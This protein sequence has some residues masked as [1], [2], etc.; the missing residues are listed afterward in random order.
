M[1]KFDEAMLAPPEDNMMAETIS[2]LLQRLTPQ[3]GKESLLQAFMPLLPPFSAVQ[4]IE[5]HFP[6]SRVWYR[7]FEEGI[8]ETAAVGYQGTVVDCSLHAV[9]LSDMLMVEIRFIRTKGSK[10]SVQ[11]SSLFNW[12]VRIMTPVLE[13]LLGQAEQQAT[14]HTL[15]KERDHHRVLVDITNAVL[16]HRDRDELIA[17]VTREI[18]H[19]FGIT[20]VGMVLHDNRPSAGFVL[21][22]TH[23]S[24]TPAE[25]LQ[26]P[27]TV[28]SALMQRISG[29]NQHALLHQAEDPLL[30]QHDPLLQDL[31]SSGLSCALL[32]PLTF[33]RHTSGLLL[34]AHSSSCL[35]SDEN[36]TLLQHIANR[37]AI[38]VDNADAWHNMNDLKEQLKQ[39]NNQLNE[40]LHCSQHV[41]DIIYQSQV[42]EE[43]LQQ[44]GIV[45]QSDSTV[46]LCGETGTGKE[47][48]A[49]TIHQ[50]SLRHDKPLVKINCAAIPAALLESELFGH[51]KGAFTGA[52][53]THRGRFEIA[54]GGTLFLDEIGDLPLELQPKLLRVLQEKEIERLGGNRTIPVNVRVIAAT[55]RDLWQMVEDRQFRSDL[56]YRLNVFPLELP[57]LRDRPEDIPLLAKYFTQKM[58][59]SMKRKIDAI[60]TDTLRQLM[61][62]E[63]PGNVRELEN[64][65]ERAVLLTRGGSLN[66][67]LHPRQTR[68]LP[69][70]SENSFTQGQ[71]AQMFN[72]ATPENDEEER[73]R[74]IQVLRE[75]NGIVAGPRGA[76]TRLGMKRTTLLSRMQRLGIAVRE[77]L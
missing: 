18:H 27:L 54:D 45:A 73:L 6:G 58:A 64:V 9:L 1:T 17:D 32:L 37:I 8:S 63:W 24:P 49:R 36:C 44:V 21:D 68:L 62:W 67:H 14:L 70:M 52:I 34:L 7:C 66:L 53:N 41:G 65:I 10:F 33:G 71:M 77:V 74:I 11:D 57:P 51:D 75:T 26:R 15:I 46:L 25:R 16:T 13:S 31:H 35:F 76:A 12:L 29:S 38:A 28:E 50:L 40:Q 61:S 39:E 72:P 30:W 47:V 48:I 60:S 23:F 22:I 19:F 4:L 59:R 20:S 69:A 2:G 5:L 43:L 55:N 42:M 56:F 3:S